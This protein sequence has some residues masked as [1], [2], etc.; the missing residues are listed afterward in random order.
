MLDQARC[1]EIFSEICKYSDADETELLVAGGTLDLTR[2]ANN[3]IHQNVAE[4]G[5]VFSVRTV[6]GGGPRGGTTTPVPRR[7]LRGTG[8]V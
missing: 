6:Y 7:A 2:F 8:A 3:T 5:Y 4:E 1:Q